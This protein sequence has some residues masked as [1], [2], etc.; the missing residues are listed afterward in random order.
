MLIRVIILMLICKPPP[1]PTHSGGW[2]L[3]AD[4][5]VTQWQ[6]G[7]AAWLA[8]WAERAAWRWGWRPRSPGWPEAGPA[9]GWGGWYVSLG[10]VRH[11]WTGEGRG[12]ATDRWAAN[13]LNTSW[14]L[15]ADFT[16]E[17]IWRVSHLDRFRSTDW[18]VYV[19]TNSLLYFILQPQ[20]DFNLLFK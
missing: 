9:A 14:E 16:P 3:C 17:G 11:L 10:A 12:G 8:V 20:L 13:R 19:L 18:R 7:G 1:H 4:L 2:W 15:G 6:G 5:T